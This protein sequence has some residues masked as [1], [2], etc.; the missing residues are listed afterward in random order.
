[1][2]VRCLPGNASNQA[3]SGWRAGSK[4]PPD[5]GADWA[6]ASLDPKTRAAPAAPMAEISDRRAEP[7]FIAVSSGM[8]TPFLCREANHIHERGAVGYPFAH[9]ILPCEEPTKLNPR[10]YAA[11]VTV[12][13]A[14]AAP[15]VA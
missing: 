14:L 15:A 8:R 12:C 1:M 9:E 5:G 3:S 7:F 13:L 6:L 10:T 11:V 2:T 4:C